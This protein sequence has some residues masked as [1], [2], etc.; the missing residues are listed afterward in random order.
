MLIDTRWSVYLRQNLQAEV[1]S[2]TEKTQWK[3]PKKGQRLYAE[4]ENDKIALMHDPYA[5]AWK[6]VSQEKLIPE[7]VGHIPKEFSRATW[8]FLMRG[9]KISGSVFEEK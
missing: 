5:V 8:F 4:K 3:S 6:M 9:G 1:G 2:S 7:T